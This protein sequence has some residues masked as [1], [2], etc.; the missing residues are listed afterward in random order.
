[1][2]RSHR[3]FAAVAIALASIP[4]AVAASP[5]VTPAQIARAVEQHL[6]RETAGLP[7]K[8]T[9]TVGALDPRLAMP[10]CSVTDTF[11]PPGSRLWGNASVGVRCTAPSPWTIFVPVTVRVEGAYLAAARPLSHGQRIADEDVLVQ[12]GDLAQLPSGVLTDVAQARGKTMTVG[13]AAGQ[14]LRHDALRAPPVVVQ[15]QSVRIVSEGPGFRVTN[16]GRALGNAVEG[17]LVQVRTPSGS[18]VS[19]VARAGS[20]VEVRY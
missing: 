18:A 7:G 16:E 11:L 5:V 8:V 1:M 14:P 15:G 9:Y 4:P 12:T 3:T 6:Q 19:G 20:V 13:L 17:Q 10:A 2:K